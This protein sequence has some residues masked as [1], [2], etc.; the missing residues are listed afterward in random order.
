MTPVI[1]HVAETLRGGTASYLDEILPR[2]VREIGAGRVHVLG[3]DAHLQDLRAHSGVIFHSFR[4]D[5]RRARHVLRLANR[6]LKL[7]SHIRPDLVHVHGTFAGVAIRTAHAAT[8]GRSGLVYC[9]HGWAFDRDVAPWKQSVAALVERALSPLGDATVCISNHDRDSALSRGLPARSLHTVRNAIGL[10][11]V[12]HAVAEWP[13]DG[14]RRVLF[15]GRFDRQKGV[16]V[17]LQAM[18]RLDGL[19]EAWLAGS[20]VVSD[21][22]RAALPGNVKCTGWLDRTQL[23]AFYESCDLVVVP[24]RWEGFGLVALEAMR[25]GKPVVATRVGG[26]PELVVHGQT[27]LLIEPDDPAALASA[28]QSPTS[29]ELR[30]MGELGRLKWRTEFSI[31]R[32]DRELMALYKEVLTRRQKVGSAALPS[33]DP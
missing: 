24:S 15:V 29:A 11:A 18:Q 4:H 22:V 25:A 7:R 28:I 23:Q 10:Q 21:G 33:I 32:L 17:L 6:Y 31:E 1:C 5:G 27:G 26:L 30:E 13:G 20:S 16:D 12:S 14:R 19:A 9:A 2:Q 3:P 8:L